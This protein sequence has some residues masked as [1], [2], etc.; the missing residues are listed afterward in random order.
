MKVNGGGIQELLC[1]VLS[2]IIKYS[3]YSL[4]LGVGVAG[5]VKLSS[6]FLA[7]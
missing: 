1:T 4:F 3:T 6:Y 7:V 5:E 2:S